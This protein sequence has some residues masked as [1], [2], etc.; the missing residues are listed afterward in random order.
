LYDSTKAPIKDTM[1]GFML[2]EISLLE[3]ISRNSRKHVVPDAVPTSQVVD[4]YK[5]A[6]S[7]SVDAL[8]YFVKLMVNSGM[9]EAGVREQLIKY[10]TEHFRTPGT[11]NSGIAAGSFRTKYKNVT[12]TTSVS[13]RASLMAMIKLID[14]EF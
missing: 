6:F 2:T 10:I 12:Q 14:K 13:V 3:T 9:I 7:M 1:Y 4:P 8:A 11:S 5:V